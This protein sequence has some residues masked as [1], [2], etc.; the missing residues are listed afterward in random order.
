MIIRQNVEGR[1]KKG[2]VAYSGRQGAKRT[3]GT[4]GGSRGA[5]VYE[6]IDSCTNLTSDFWVK[7]RNSGL[8]RVNSTKCES[9]RRWWSVGGFLSGLSCESRS[10]MNVALLVRDCPRVWQKIRRSNC[11]SRRG[12]T[13][14]RIGCS[15]RIFATLPLCD[16]ALKISL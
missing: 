11:S 16:F 2:V 14:G 13:A 12:G 8:I 7:E 15:P 6:S 3:E 4:E 5:A 10:D 1:M 9:F